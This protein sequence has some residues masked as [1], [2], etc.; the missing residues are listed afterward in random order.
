MADL[1]EIAFVC[2][3]L[4]HQSKQQLVHSASAV[5]GH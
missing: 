3:I 2:E 5:F 1:H 4:D